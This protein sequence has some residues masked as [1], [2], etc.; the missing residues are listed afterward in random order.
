MLAVAVGLLAATPGCISGAALTVKEAESKPIKFGVLATAFALEAG[1]FLALEGARDDDFGWYYAG[2][3]GADMLLALAVGRCESCYGDLPTGPVGPPTPPTPPREV[4]P[5]EAECNEAGRVM[6][7]MMTD[8]D[9]RLYVQNRIR[10]A[11]SWSCSSNEWSEAARRC[12][13]S[14]YTQASHAACL[15]ELTEAQIQDLGDTTD[16]LTEELKGW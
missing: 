15:F 12:M 6:G 11:V 3:V 16:R 10:D 7:L 13:A 9:D 8:Q 14:A 1:L 4:S 5:R 2:T